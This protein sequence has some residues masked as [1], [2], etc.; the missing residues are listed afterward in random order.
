MSDHSHRG[1]KPPGTAQTQDRRVLEVIDG[2]TA[3]E[4]VSG[5]F[6]LLGLARDPTR[7]VRHKNTAL[8]RPPTFARGVVVH[9]LPHANWYKVQLGEGGGWAAACCLG[10]AGIPMGPKPVDMPGPGDSVALFRPAGLNYMFILGVIPPI[11][12]DG[13]VSCPD[14][15]VQG[16]TSGLKRSAGHQYPLRSLYKGGGVLDFSANRPQ[17][18]TA[19]EK[20]WVAPTG[21]AIT[22]DDYMAQVR[23]DESCGLWMTL[24]DSWCRLAGRQLL[25]ESAAHEVEAG[26]DEGEARYFEGCAGYPWEALGQTDSGTGWTT[27]ASDSDV[28]YKGGKAKVEPSDPAAEPVYRYREY[29]GYLGQ[30][31]VREVVVPGDSPE[32]VFREAVGFDGSVSVLSAKSLH[33][34]RRVMLGTTARLKRAEAAGGDD[35]TAGNYKF[36]SK[37]GSGGDHKV[38]D[39]KAEGEPKSM[40]KAAAALDLNAYGGWKALHPFHYHTADYSVTADGTFER[41]QDSLDYSGEDSYLADPEPIKVKVDHRYG[42]VEFFQR[43]SFLRFH[44]DGTV[45]LAAG[46]GEELL[47]GGGRIRLSCPLGMELL[48]GAELVAWAEQIL[49][50]AKGSVDISS[51]EKDVHVK[52]EVNVQ[53]LAGNG[54]KGSV[55]VESRGEGDDHDYLNKYGEDAEGSGIVL[56]ARKGQLALLGQDVYVRSGGEELGDG[57][58][59]LDAGKGTR[60]CQV[61]AQEFHT[62]TTKGNS[63]AFGPTGEESNVDK[64]YSFGPEQA[65][66]DVQLMVR[67]KIIG[68]GENAG[69]IVRGGIYATKAVATAGVMA[70]KKGMFLGKVG[71][72]FE[73]GIRASAAAAKSGADQ[74]K[75]TA[76]SRHKTSVVERVYGDKKI[77]SDDVLAAAGFSFRDPPDSQDQYKTS[78]IKFPEPRWQQF[79]RLGLATGGE[80]WTE[81]PVEYQGRD[82]YPWPGKAKLV[83]EPSLLRLESLKMFDPEGGA[84][85]PF[86]YEDPALAAWEPATLDGEYLLTR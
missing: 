43:E 58:I 49:L 4:A 41:V 8:G 63:F 17:D 62:Y 3:V 69:I 31:R 52:A 53:V 37:F 60:R 38:G 20:G 7:V 55:L 56:K 19:L 44:D 71:A 70:D 45:Q 68:Y 30:G 73:A 80:P 64:V 15:V 78:K 47:M 23:V 29:G 18:Q 39:V 36:S 67:D 1:A 50:R 81:N 65:V 77:G 27:E 24:W 54:G 46:G 5:A 6:P 13:S 16:S 35:A 72:G 25:V 14:W 40:L 12:S 21:L 28:Q 86:P 2:L 26:D 32:T 33:I 84:D 76:K 75:E 9:A 74:L 83:D 48:P 11:G 10:G 61:Y 79:A 66:L 51:T 85:E 57:D 34:G 42:D 59:L 82:T 22:V